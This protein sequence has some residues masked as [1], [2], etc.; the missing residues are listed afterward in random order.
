MI[1]VIR[2]WVVCAIMERSYSRNNLA[3]YPSPKCS[4]SRTEVHSRFKADPNIVVH[5]VLGDDIVPIV[6]LDSTRLVP[7]GIDVQ[8]TPANESRIG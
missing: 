5:V 8:L 7:H 6:A 3:T 2:F 1:D 4:I